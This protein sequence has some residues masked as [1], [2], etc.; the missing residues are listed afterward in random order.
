MLSHLKD[1]EDYVTKRRALGRKGQS[2]DQAPQEATSKAKAKAKGK[3]KA[4][5]EAA[6]A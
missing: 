6:D 4:S 5:S 3:A 1:A 2:E